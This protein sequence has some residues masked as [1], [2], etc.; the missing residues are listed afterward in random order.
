MVK[1]IATNSIW[2]G[3]AKSW[4]FQS[5]PLKPNV[6]DI[7]NYQQLIDMGSILIGQNDLPSYILGVTPELYFLLTELKMNPYAIDCNMDMIKKVWPGNMASTFHHQWQ[8][9]QALRIKSNFLLCDGGLHLLSYDHQDK[10]LTALDEVISTGGCFI[11]RLFLPP[12]HKLSSSDEVLKKFELEKFNLSYLK[13]QLWHS[14]NLNLGGQVDLSDIWE[15]LYRWSGGNVE[16]RLLHMGFQDSEIKTLFSY[17]SGNAK[18]YFRSFDQICENLERNTS[19]KIKKILYPN[20]YLGS[21]FPTVMFG[22]KQ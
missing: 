20:Y 17:A 16:E 22:R 13:V 14:H 4:K 12:Q 2:D 15:V 1:K 3:H 10:V 9:L 8:D 11:T 18:Y 6:L 21:Q 5:T 7:N 19:F